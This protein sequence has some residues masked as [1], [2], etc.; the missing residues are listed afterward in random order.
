MDL[1]KANDSLTLR[2][3]LNICYFLIPIHFDHTLCTE[4]SICLKAPETKPNIFVKGGNFGI[5]S[6]FGSPG[7][8]CWVPVAL[9]LIWPIFLAVMLFK[10][11]NFILSHQCGGKIPHIDQ[12]SAM[13]SL[14]KI[15]CRLSTSHQNQNR[16]FFILL[17]QSGYA[18][19]Y[20]TF[21]LTHLCREKKPIFIC[22]KAV[23]STFCNFPSFGLTGLG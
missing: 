8:V 7:H 1:I 13:R 11:T 23:R 19:H 15:G 9:Y 17:I 4:K 22:S 14:I 20:H 21:C 5:K 2:V 10:L 3:T 12:R 18:I 16:Q 6:S